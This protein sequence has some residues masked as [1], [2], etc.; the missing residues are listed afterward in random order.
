MTVVKILAV[1]RILFFVD[2]LFLPWNVD[3]YS[4]IRG[5]FTVLL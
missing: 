1:L 3:D 5:N 2:I 4:E